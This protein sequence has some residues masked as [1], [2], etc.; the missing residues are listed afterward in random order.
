MS[1]KQES[2]WSYEAHVALCGALADALVAVGSSAAANKD[3]IQ[4]SL[5]SK[6]FDFT[7]EAI[8]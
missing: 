1:K 6:G 5:S 8:R 2:K 4:A 3:Q 7:W